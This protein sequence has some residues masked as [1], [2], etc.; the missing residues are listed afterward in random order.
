MCDWSEL[1]SDQ[2]KQPRGTNKEAARTSAEWGVCLLA[3]LRLPKE[4][5]AV[6]ELRGR[7]LTHT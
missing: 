3:H 5:D 4:K 6:V 1:W 7:G 2:P